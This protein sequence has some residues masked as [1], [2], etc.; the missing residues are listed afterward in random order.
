[1]W[2]GLNVIPAIL[3]IYLQQQQQ[4]LI[5]LTPCSHVQKKKIIINQWHWPPEIT[6]KL[7][8]NLYFFA[9]CRKNVES[10]STVAAVIVHFSEPGDFNRVGTFR[11][12][13]DNKKNL[14]GI[15]V[16]LFYVEANN[17]N[18]L[19]FHIHQFNATLFVQIFPNLHR[20]M[21]KMKTLAKV[22][23]CGK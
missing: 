19:S 15:P 17:G 10:E 11:G 2:I 1:M 22:I 12:W 4:Q 6:K 21:R 3:L 18:Q 23:V 14:S 5:Y 8:C 20:Q 7:I 13:I 9:R 16:S